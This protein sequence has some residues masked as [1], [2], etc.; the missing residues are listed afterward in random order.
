MDMMVKL[1]KDGTLLYSDK[2][3]S[4][5]NNL[6]LGFKDLIERIQPEDYSTELYDIV[7]EDT[8]TGVIKKYVKK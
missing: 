8:I 7:Y 2:Y 3:I 5:V 6:R 1:Y 4:R